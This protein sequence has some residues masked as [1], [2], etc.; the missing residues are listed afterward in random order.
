MSRI[1][2]ERRQG[3][4]IEMLQISLGR[5]G[6]ELDAER[7]GKSHDR[8]TVSHAAFSADVRSNDGVRNCG[9]RLS[10]GGPSFGVVDPECNLQPLIPQLSSLSAL[11]LIRK[12][13]Q[14][15]PSNHDFRVKLQTKQSFEF[16]D[17]TSLPDEGS[18][19]CSEGTRQEVRFA[20][21]KWMKTVKGMKKHYP[22]Y[23]GPVLRGRMSN[24]ITPRL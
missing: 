23:R 8:E 14:F 22:I 5:E 2:R 20:L 6:E 21:G 7:K 12:W 10:R 24:S 4:Q 15:L 3:R 19:H 1:K 13:T 18:R 17:S 16:N 11:D 9:A